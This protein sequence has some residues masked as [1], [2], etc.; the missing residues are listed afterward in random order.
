MFDFVKMKVEQ[1]VTEKLGITNKAFVNLIVPGIMTM[2]IG[3]VLL[4]VA[5]IVISA[6]ITGVVG[7]TATVGPVN[8]TFNSSF[9]ATVAVI[10][11]AMGIAGIALIIVGIAMIVYTLYGLAGGSGAGRR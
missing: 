7:T 8:S 1:F 3:G 2:L 5:Y 4:I 9:W 11:Q 10:T 6:V